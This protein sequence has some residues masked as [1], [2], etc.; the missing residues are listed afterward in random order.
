LVSHINAKYSKTHP[1]CAYKNWTTSLLKPHGIQPGLFTSIG[2]TSLEW[3]C[4][5]LE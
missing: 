1:S 2:G 4:R 5:C 3:C